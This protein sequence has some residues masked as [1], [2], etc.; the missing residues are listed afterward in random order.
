MEMSGFRNFSVLAEFY[1]KCRLLS[2]GWLFI[3]N[4]SLARCDIE[5]SWSNYEINDPRLTLIYCQILLK[6]GHVMQ[7]GTAGKACLLH[8]DKHSKM[9]T[10]CTIQLLCPL[11]GVDHCNAIVGQHFN[12]LKL[13]R[14]KWTLNTHLAIDLCCYNFPRLVSFTQS[15]C[16]LTRD[17]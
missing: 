11:N 10:T 1:M 9:R 4:S 7:T 12:S 15:S 17:Q 13:V 14:D 5:P 3:Y 8:K 16:S 2:K 6:F